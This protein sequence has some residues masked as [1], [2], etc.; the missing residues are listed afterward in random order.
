MKTES[1]LKALTGSDNSHYPTSSP[2]ISGSDVGSV[3][4]VVRHIVLSYLLITSF[5]E[6]NEFGEGNFRVK[7]KKEL[8]L[9]F[10]HIHTVLKTADTVIVVCVV[11]VSVDVVLV[12]FPV[13]SNTWNNGS[14][15]YS[16]SYYRNQQYDLWLL[17]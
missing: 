8:S 2:E 10:Y 9:F 7:R 14:H 15:W 3:A 5:L 4:N 1:R 11:S 17:A 13:A 16:L 12:Q 6:N